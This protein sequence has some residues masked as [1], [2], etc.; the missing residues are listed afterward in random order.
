M[1]VKK[2]IVEMVGCVSGDY[3]EQYIEQNFNFET[4]L[5]IKIENLG[6]EAIVSVED[7]N[8]L[9]FS[10]YNP[11]IFD[12]GIFGEQLSEVGLWAKMARK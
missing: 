4:S 8:P 5:R 9:Y 10:E 7:D 2:E 6:V 1:L 11:H 12:F 3:V